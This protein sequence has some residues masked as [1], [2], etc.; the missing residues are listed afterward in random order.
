MKKGQ[1]T[2]YCQ[3]CGK[4]ISELGPDWCASCLDV[5]EWMLRGDNFEW[6]GWLPDGWR[7]DL[8]AKERP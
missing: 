1:H 3:H 7:I 5:D 2:K 8:I 4:A 6:I